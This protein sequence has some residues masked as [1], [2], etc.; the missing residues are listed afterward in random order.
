MLPGNELPQIV[1]GATSDAPEFERPPRR[2]GKSGPSVEGWRSWG[3]RTRTLKVGAKNRCVANYTTPQQQAE[4]R[5]RPDRSR[6]V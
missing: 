2:R 5:Y 4:R 3:G 1:G 6:G